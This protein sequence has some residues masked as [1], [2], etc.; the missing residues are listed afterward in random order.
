VAKPDI[1]DC[2]S[3]EARGGLPSCRDEERGRYAI[4]RRHYQYDLN[5]AGARP[6]LG[7]ADY[8][9]AFVEFDDQGWFAKRQQMEALMMLLQQIER[10]DQA[11][12]KSGHTPA[13]DRAS[14][15]TVRRARWWTR[16]R[17]GEPPMTTRRRPAGQ[18]PASRR[19]GSR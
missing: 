14:R 3:A 7:A 6:T 2:S 11:S 15:P 18:A 17:Q 13:S 19:P 9:L 4:Q 8:Y 16:K 10:E 5:P 12:G 1:V